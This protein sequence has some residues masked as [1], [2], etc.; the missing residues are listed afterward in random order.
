MKLGLGPCSVL[1]RNKHIKRMEAYNF[2]HRVKISEHRFKVEIVLQGSL[3]K[4][5][6][7]AGYD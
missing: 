6:K 4:T 1:V 7:V 2:H 5:K 3:V